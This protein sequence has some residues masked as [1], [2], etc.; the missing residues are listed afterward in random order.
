MLAQI[1]GLIIMINVTILYLLYFIK[2]L[3]LIVLPIYFIYKKL[4]VNK[5]LIVADIVILLVFGCSNLFGIG[6]YLSKTNI[7]DIKTIVD[8]K[9]MVVTNNNEDT[10]RIINTD[11]K[12]SNKL[13]SSSYKLQ[14][15][16][17]NSLSNQFPDTSNLNQ[18]EKELLD[19]FYSQN[20]E[21]NYIINLSE[22]GIFWDSEPTNEN[23]TAGIFKTGD[24]I[25]INYNDIDWKYGDDNTYAE[26][27]YN[28]QKAQLDQK[29]VPILYVDTNNYMYSYTYKDYGLSGNSI[30]YYYKSI[31]DDGG[32]IIR[33]RINDNKISNIYLI[34]EDYYYHTKE[35]FYKNN[36]T[37]KSIATIILF[38]GILA[39]IIYIIVKLGKR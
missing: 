39:I 13:V 34:Y 35:D 11:I 31:Y 9:S 10:S 1:V 3:A 23:D 24:S 14:E 18:E 20:T 8:Q 38:F 4:E 26:L 6:N 27:V 7:Y 21:D 28:G 36:N 15:V 33:F 25:S 2:M 30:N 19:N 16:V 12:I 37:P 29:L 22:I 17:Y 32:L 5:Y